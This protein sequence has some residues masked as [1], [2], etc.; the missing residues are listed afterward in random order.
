MSTGG[1]AS[2]HLIHGDWRLPPLDPGRT[3]L[4]WIEPIIERTAALLPVALDFD[5]VCHRREVVSE[6]RLAACDPEIPGIVL[7]AAANP[8]GLPYRLIDGNHRL[9]RLRGAGRVR[10]PFFVLDFADVADCVLDYDTYMRNLRGRHGRPRARSPEAAP[11]RFPGVPGTR[12]RP[13][14]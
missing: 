3:W 8:C 6:D 9:H 12:R 13:G 4:I 2:F 1:H 7:R 11:F 10:G 14:G 5:Q